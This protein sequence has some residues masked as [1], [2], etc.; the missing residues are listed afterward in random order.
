M[1]ESSSSK[2]DKDH[3]GGGKKTTTTYHYSPNWSSSKIDSSKFKDPKH[4]DDNN[5]VKFFTDEEI[6]TAKKVSLDAYNLSASQIDRMSNYKDIILDRSATNQFSKKTR[7]DIHRLNWGQPN[8]YVEGNYVYIKQSHGQ[9][10]RIGDI[11][12]SF[13]KVPCEW[14]TVV[15]EQAASTFVPYNIKRRQFK[16]KTDAENAKLTDS[17]ETGC[18]HEV[19]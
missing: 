1:K 12:I 5:R 11:R 3:F 17:L 8:I 19:S 2:T 7:D 16:R 13:S 14:V 15:A 10:S 4:R 9:E 18:C 6:F